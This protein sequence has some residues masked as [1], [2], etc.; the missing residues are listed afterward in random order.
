MRAFFVICLA[1][2]ALC[3]VVGHFP[4]GAD[5]PPASTLPKVEAELARRG[6]LKPASA[7]AGIGD[8]NA[9]SLALYAEAAKVITHP[10]CMNC[11]PADRS[12]RQGAA[13]RIHIPPMTG[14]QDGHG[15]AG[16]PCTTCHGR[17]NFVVGGEN[18]QSIPGNPAWALAPAAM[19]W[20]GKT[21]GEI[22]RQ[23]KDPARNGGKD[24]EALYRHM[25]ED[26][27]VGWGWTPGKGRAPAPGDQATFGG[28]IRAWIDSGAACPA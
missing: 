4:A 28:L 13:G 7:F 3:I 19:A 23:I 25:A 17:E 2:F 22:C 9:R 11:H 8:R 1:T 26:D 15:P 14:G 16:Q 18:I 24:L 21:P 5:T 27:L 6:A 12:P 10:R 20:Q